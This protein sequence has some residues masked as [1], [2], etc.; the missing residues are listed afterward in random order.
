MVVIL[1][2]QID[3]PPERQRLEAE[4][5]EAFATLGTLFEPR[6]ARIARVVSLALDGAWAEVVAI[7]EQSDLHMLRLLGSTLLAPLARQQGNAALAWTLVRE[8]LPAGPDT[9]PEDSV[10]YILPL[11]TL[12]VTLA[13]DADDHDAARQWLAALDRWLAWSGSVLGQADAHLGWATYYR[14]VGESDRARTRAT[15]AL[16][17]A[18]APRQP[19]ALLAAHR[20]MGELDL[21]AGQ[22]ADAEAQ[23]AA[24]LTLADACAARHERG[25]TLLALA[26]WCRTRGDIPAARA[27]L[28]TVRALCTPM[29]AALALAQADALAERLPALPAGPSPVRRAGLTARE[30]EVVRLL[31]AGLT[32]AEI[33]AHLSLSPRTV[34]A[35]L[36]TIY[37]KLGVATRGAAIRFA[38]DH[39][40]R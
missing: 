27:H 29:G 20:L 32:N 36:T 38:L 17:A 14:A 8:G 6:A 25:L 3:Q 37:G 33:A 1:P 4:L 39:G 2:Y 12:A 19:L 13:L 23:L 34:N 30:V 26:E 5:G 18:A 10:C 22:L 15:Q 24:A 35:H 9:P 11:R 40:L 28:D 7:L 16:V 31:A 21:A